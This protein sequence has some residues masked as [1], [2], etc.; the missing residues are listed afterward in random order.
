MASGQLGSLR[1]FEEI[2]NFKS[3]LFVCANGK[4]QVVLNRAFVDGI[5]FGL[6]VTV[7]LFN[8]YC[9]L[10]AELIDSLQEAVIAGLNSVIVS[11]LGS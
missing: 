5:P 6:G 3:T 8:G 11:R 10:S 1:V 9:S 4:T 2:G 7:L